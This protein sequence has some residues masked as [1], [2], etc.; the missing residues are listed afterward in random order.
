[1][2]CEQH[3]NRMGDLSRKS[4]LGVRLWNSVVAVFLAHSGAVHCL[5]FSCE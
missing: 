5:P 2:S 4:V 1:M 3:L